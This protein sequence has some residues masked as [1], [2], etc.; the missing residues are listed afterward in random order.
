M[1][2]KENAHRA[3][4]KRG[5]KMEKTVYKVECNGT[6]LGSYSRMDGAIIAYQYYV[7]KGRGNAVYTLTRYNG[8]WK[9]QFFPVMEYEVFFE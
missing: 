8:N 2:V 6:C 7:R 1:T 9:K 3:K 5:S 4:L